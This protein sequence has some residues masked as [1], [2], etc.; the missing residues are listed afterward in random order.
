ML[1]RSPWLLGLDLARGCNYYAVTDSDLDLSSVPTDLLNVLSAGLQKFPRANKAGLS[2]ELD[3]LPVS[4]A[5]TQVREWEAH[6]WEKRL[7]SQFFDADV[8]TTF[9][10]YRAGTGWGG[11]GGP[12]IRTDRPYTARHVPWY[13]TAETITAE[14]R[15]YLDHCDRAHSAWAGRIMESLGASA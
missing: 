14:E 2:L 5:T 8:D 10:L 3:D 13:M 15:Y 12:A 6:F 7:D 9:A 4:R 1:F 11:N